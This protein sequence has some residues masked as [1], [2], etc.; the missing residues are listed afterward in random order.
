MKNENIDIGHYARVPYHIA[1]AKISSRARNLWTILA[2]YA[3]PEKPEVW[4]RLGSMAEQLDCS[5]DSV[6]RA[7][8]E[9]RQAKYLFLVQCRFF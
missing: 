9:L 4:T 3:T 5:I 8:K 1:T 6:E 7:I 2:L